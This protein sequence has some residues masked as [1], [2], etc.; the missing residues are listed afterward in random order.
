MERIKRV[1]AGLAACAAFMSV[2]AVGVAYGDD[3]HTLP[4]GG[5]GHTQQGDGHSNPGGEDGFGHVVGGN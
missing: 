5:Y 3:G 2:G 4:D 1:L